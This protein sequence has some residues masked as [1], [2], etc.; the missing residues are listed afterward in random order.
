MTMDGKGKK[1]LAVK[2]ID[3]SLLVKELNEGLF[4]SQQ[5]LAKRCGVSQ[6]C[7]SH[8]KSMIKT[9][10][11]Q[12]RHRLLEIARK[13]NLN[14][15]K[16]EIPSDRDAIAKHLDDNRGKEL[17]KVFELFRKMKRRAQTKFLRYA[18]TLVK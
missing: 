18:N 13:E 5:E 2:K 16:F 4:I 1:N 8:W 15:G 7:I 3:W 12:T 10:R 6:Q 14:I 9:P 11:P 17:I